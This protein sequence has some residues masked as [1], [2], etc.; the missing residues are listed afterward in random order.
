MPEMDVCKSSISSN[1]S[2]R[3][4]SKQVLVGAKTAKTHPTE[5]AFPSDPSSISAPSE[6]S[7]SFLNFK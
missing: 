5:D 6:D 4:A 7:I 2:L 1:S 3:I